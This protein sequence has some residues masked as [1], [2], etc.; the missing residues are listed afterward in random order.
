MRLLRL[1][2]SVR[3][4]SG[5]CLCHSRSR[6][7]GQDN[8][9]SWSHSNTE[10][11]QTPR[12]ARSASMAHWPECFDQLWRAITERVGTGAGGTA[13]RRRVDALPRTRARAG[14]ARGPW[15]AGRRRARR[16]RRG[17]P[18]TPLRAASSPCLLTGLDARLTATAARRCRISLATTSCST[19]RQTSD[20]RPGE[21]TSAR[22]ARSRRT[23]ANCTSRRDQA[24][25]SVRWPP[26][27]SASNRHPLAYLAALLEAE[28]AERAE[29]RERRRLLDARF[30]IVK[31]LEDFRFD[32][33]H[34]SPA[35]NDR[36]AR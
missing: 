17:R 14:R 21:D 36:R 30:P 18:G 3:E 8:P 27:R 13:D 7:N 31:R 25:G 12:S 5:E 15:R 19:A 10:S 2:A 29:R 28:I 4:A 24:P 26:K 33:E 35:S 6:G 34:E 16:P 22:G 32:R 23:H 1:R 11:R 20:E 9:R